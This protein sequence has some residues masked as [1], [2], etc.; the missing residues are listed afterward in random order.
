MSAT[1]RPREPTVDELDLHPVL[2]KPGGTASPC[3]CQADCCFGEGDPPNNCEYCASI[4]GELPCP[5]AD[6]E[7]GRG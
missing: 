1:A 7:V 2:V 3:C 5:I 6:A 4:D